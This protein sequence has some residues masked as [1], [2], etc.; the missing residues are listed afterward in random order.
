MPPA[1]RAAARAPG[2]RRGARLVPG[3][4]AR[5]VPGGVRAW[6]RRG[7]RCAHSPRAEPAAA[8]FTVTRRRLHARPVRGVYKPRI[9]GAHNRRDVRERTGGPRPLGPGRGR[10]RGRPERETAGPRARAAGTGGKPARGVRP[11]AAGAARS[12]RRAI[13]WGP[14]CLLRNQHEQ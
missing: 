4:G 7:A 11:S 3:G 6:S 14:S 9:P 5:L 12:G 10:S 13:A 1:V 2:P 8:G